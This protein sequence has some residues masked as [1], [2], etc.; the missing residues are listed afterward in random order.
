MGAILGLGTTDFPM[1][2][3]ADGSLT[4]VLDAGLKGEH[5]TEET[6]DQSKW[7]EP[8]RKELGD[9]HGVKTGAEKR[10]RQI[11]QFRKLRGALDDFKPDLILIWSKDNR[12]SLKNF[13]LPPFWVQAYEKVDVKLFQVFG[14]TDNFFGEDP[15]RVDT[16]AGHPAAANLLINGLQDEGF[17]VTYA[18]EPMHPNGLGHTFC[19]IITHL[20][21][22]KREFK[23]PVIPVSMNQFAD[24]TRLPDG[25]SP[26]DPAAPR[27]MTAKRAFELGRATARI[28]KASPWRVAM[29]AGVGWSH[30]QN[31]SWDRQ[32][33]HPDME[34]DRRFHQQWVNNKFDKWGDIT[35]EELEE[36]G[37]WELLSWIALAG[38]MTEVGAKVVHSDLEENWSYNSNWVNT[39][40]STAE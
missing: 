9:D 15:E 28:F 20:D 23:T 16:I 11:E 38:A 32:W 1:I 24:R 5:Y 33:V 25:L 12:E 2:R 34:G 39:I 35:A 8:M 3:L 27:P 40:F 21:W 17:D 31:T 7:P 37:N 18:R 10:A 19:G 29:V 36:T 4:G 22:D 6:K 13:A 14:N 26:I 30:A